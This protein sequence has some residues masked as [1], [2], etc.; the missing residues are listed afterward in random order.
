MSVKGQA[1][2]Y[3]QRRIA[4]KL[5]RAV[6]M[7]GA[8]VA[9]GTLAASI[10]RKGPVGGAVDTVLD[11][12]PFVSGVKNAVEIVRGRDLIADTPV[13]QPAGFGRA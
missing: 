12:I 3:M 1:A 13:R 4:R 5:L 10:R 9:L 8:L 11:F 6:P 7:L 2:Q